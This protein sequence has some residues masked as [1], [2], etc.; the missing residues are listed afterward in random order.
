MRG[1]RCWRVREAWPLLLGEPVRLLS[2]DNRRRKVADDEADLM[3]TAEVARFLGLSRQRVLKLSQ[4]AAFPKPLAVLSM[5]KVWR[6]EDI[7]RWHAARRG[8]GPKESGRAGP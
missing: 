1:S 3:G 6:G 4:G 7:R 2:I 5:G 8:E